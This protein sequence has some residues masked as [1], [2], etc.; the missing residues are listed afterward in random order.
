VTYSTRIALSDCISAIAPMF[1]S[2]TLLMFLCA[3]RNFITDIKQAT[4]LFI[5][6]ITTLL[7]VKS[8][9]FRFIS[10][11]PCPHCRR[12]VRLSQKTATVAENAENGDSLHFS[13]TVWRG[14]KAHL[15]YIFVD[16]VTLVCSW[17]TWFYLVLI[18]KFSVQ[19]LLWCVL[20]RR[21]FNV[22]A[23]MP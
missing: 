15:L 7:S 12:K 9:H 2:C 17:S 20:Y 13:A 14:L 16:Y 23:S 3:Y 5:Y 22:W 1:V 4:A 21:S 11:K 18:W 8:C 19:R 6:S 10:V